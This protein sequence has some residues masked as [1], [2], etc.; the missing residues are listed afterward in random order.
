M[1]DEKL[2][3]KEAEA[4]NL[5][6]G[7][8]DG[9]TLPVSATDS[10]WNVYYDK[11]KNYTPKKYSLIYV[12]GLKLKTGAFPSGLDTG[13][14]KYTGGAT[15]SHV[16]GFVASRIFKLS[17]YPTIKSADLDIVRDEKDASLFE[18]RDL[19]DFITAIKKD[20]DLVTIGTQFQTQPAGQETKDK[21]NY[22]EQIFDAYF[23]VL[24]SDTSASSSAEIRSCKNV[25]LQICNGLKKPLVGNILLSILAKIY[26]DPNITLKID[27]RVVLGLNNIFAARIL[28]SEDVLNPRRIT[29]TVAYNKSFYDYNETQIDKL[30]ECFR[31]A[32]SIKDY[33]VDAFLA[34][35]MPDPDKNLSEQIGK[36]LLVITTANPTDDLLSRLADGH[37]YDLTNDDDVDEIKNYFNPLIGFKLDDNGGDIINKWQVRDPEEADGILTWL[38]ANAKNAEEREEDNGYFLQVF[39]SSGS[40]KDYYKA[41][42]SILSKQLEFSGVNVKTGDIIRL[43][44][45][46]LTDV[47]N[48]R[49]SDYLSSLPATYYSSDDDLKDYLKLDSSNTIALKDFNSKVKISYKKDA[50]GFKVNKVELDIAPTNVTIKFDPNGATGTIADVTLT[51]GTTYTLPDSTALTPATGYVFDSWEIGGT[52]YAVGDLISPT[53]DITIKALWKAG[54]ITVYKVSFDSNGGSGSATDATVARGTDYTFVDPTTMGITAPAGQEFSKWEVAGTQYNIGDKFTPT[55]DSVAKVIW[56]PVAAT[57][58]TITI[59]YNNGVDEAESRIIEKNKDFTF[60]LSYLNRFAPEGKEIDYIEVDGTKYNPADPFKVVNDTAT[61]KFFWKVKLTPKPIANIG[62]ISKLTSAIA[63]ANK[64]EFDSVYSGLTPEEKEWVKITYKGVD[65]SWL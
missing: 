39:S 35:G 47:E 52:K 36:H 22:T 51:S 44:K 62:T 25:I 45:C 23:N 56:K 11:Y 40:F 30:F 10:N 55:A 43:V 1:D 60:K 27:T 5:G 4:I 2:I 33:N 32:S 26:T 54:G 24:C 21:M 61:I 13:F 64:A 63:K 17:D 16:R 59:D 29:G 8:P 9:E 49:L 57:H 28:T 7:L 31:K 65:P 38:V 18:P 15:G 48:I 19:N 37:T 46:Y 12:K 42:E 3:L 41:K 14:I 34:T 58:S 6:A 50:T 53:A 20:K